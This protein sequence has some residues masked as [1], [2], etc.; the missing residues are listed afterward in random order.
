MF[1]DGT[2][3]ASTTTS[4]I[5]YDAT[6]ARGISIGGQPT[7]TWGSS[8]IDAPFTGYVSNFRVVKGA[9]FYTANFTPSTMPLIPGVNTSLLAC[10][11]STFV[12][13]SSNNLAVT[14][15]G[16]A[17]VSP[18]N[19]F[20][21]AGFASSLRWAVSTPGAPIASQSALIQ[22]RI[23]GSNIYD[24][25][26]GTAGARAVTL[27]FWVNSPVT[28]TYCVAVQNPSL[29]R[30]YVAEYTVSAANTW[31]RKTVN[32]PGPTSGFWPTDNSEGLRVSFDMGSGTNY[33]TTAGSWQVGNFTRTAGATSFSAQSLTSTELTKNFYVTGAQLE[34]GNVATPYEMITYGKQ[35]E[36][37]QRYYNIIKPDPGH[38]LAGFGVACA[39][40][41]TNALGI[42][43]F[44]QAM[45]TAPTIGQYF[46]WLHDSA[47]RAL[48][49][50]FIWAAGVG[51]HSAYIY[52]YSSGLTAGRT[53]VWTANNTDTA[54]VTLDADL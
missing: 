40:S 54:F 41:P 53:Y 31:E 27:S 15:V 24:F 2:L 47:G 13:K 33:N 25:S 36:L 4:V 32:I 35:L 37:C 46:T 9:A 23:E 11:S 51:S 50:P 21:Q 6:T 39:N 16:N 5:P 45:R 1:V 8:V 12:D 49:N 43:Y 26:W 52:F 17:A 22:Q 38:T 3:A 7:N 29:D 19:P 10:A 20:S 18:L 42:M 44:P 48:A 30:S 14:T 28:G 34:L